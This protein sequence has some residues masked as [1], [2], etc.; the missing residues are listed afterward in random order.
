MVARSTSGATLMTTR[1]PLVSLVLAVL[2]VLA[3]AVAGAQSPLPEPTEGPVA[4]ASP[5]PPL[6]AVEDEIDLSLIHISEP[7]RLC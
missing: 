7:T 4:P 2:L 1:P 3:P 5:A 6:G